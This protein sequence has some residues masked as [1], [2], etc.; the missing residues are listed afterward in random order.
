MRFALVIAVA[1]VL[2]SSATAT[3]P[4]TTKTLA[5]TW[6][7]SWTTEAFGSSGPVT[8]VAT[9]LANSRLS[10]SVDFGGSAFGCSS[11]PQASTTLSKG[12]GANHWGPTGFLIKG[13]SKDLGSLT[14][15]YRAGIRALTGNGV[16]PRCAHGLSWSVLGAFFGSTFTGKVKFK[17]ASGQTA[18]SSIS[19]TRD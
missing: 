10:L 4:F 15:R 8:F 3:G 9:P 11:V 19:L 18:I 2:A 17:L 1:A 12:T 14:L 6:R 16:N 13:A 5:G 7:G